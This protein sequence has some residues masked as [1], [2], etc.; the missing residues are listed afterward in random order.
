M[1]TYQRFTESRKNIFPAWIRCLYIG[2]VRR[3]QRTVIHFTVER[4][5]LYL[6]DNAIVSLEDTAA[7][8]EKYR[9]PYCRPEKHPFP[10]HWFT[11][12]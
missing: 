5:A 10:L 7:R 2:T 11:K 12:R 9:K 8:S 3:I 6:R 1:I 4:G